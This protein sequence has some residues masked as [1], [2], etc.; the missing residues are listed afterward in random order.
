SSE[1]WPRLRA[2]RTYQEQ[3]LSYMQALKDGEPSDGYRDLPDQ[4][5]EEWPVLQEALTSTNAR[6]RLLFAEG[7]PEVCPRCHIKLPSSEIHRLQ[8]IGIATAR[9]CCRRVV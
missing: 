4:A 6:G 2:L 3:V 7:S 9:N 5:R 1:L 8:S